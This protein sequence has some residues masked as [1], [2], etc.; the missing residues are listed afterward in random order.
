V[1]SKYS[2][3]PESI[4]LN[5][6][7]VPTDELFEVVVDVENTGNQ[8]VEA[9]HFD[10]PLTLRF[11]EQARVILAEVIEEEPQGIQASLEVDSDRVTLNPVLLNAG[12]LVCL[13]L[14][15]HR[16]DDLRAEGR[17]LGVRRVQSSVMLQRFIRMSLLDPVGLLFVIVV[18]FLLDFFPHLVSGAVAAVIFGI[19]LAAGIL[20]GWAAFKGMRAYRRLRRREEALQAKMS[21]ME[22]KFVAHGA[23]EHDAHTEEPESGRGPTQVKTD[24]GAAS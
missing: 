10:R 18:L 21:S 15:V 2:E 5:S 11:G 7:K 9:T 14:L 20:S 24:D 17:V 6:E 19:A 4:D 13:F 16:Y 8:D 22:K 3:V 1:A 23:S 12:D